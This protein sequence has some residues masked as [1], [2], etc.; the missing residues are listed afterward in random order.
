MIT[1]NIECEKIENN[2]Q[3]SIDVVTLEEPCTVIHLF[4]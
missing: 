3:S 4:L 1:D 2:T